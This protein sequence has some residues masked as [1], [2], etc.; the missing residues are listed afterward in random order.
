VS[1]DRAEAPPDFAVVDGLRIAYRSAGTGPAVV[2][3]HGNPT[4]SYLWRDVLPVLSRSARCIA[5]DLVGM[6]HSDPLPGARSPSR[7]RAAGRC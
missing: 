2:L 7:G 1:P 5:P 3:L 6:G 4:S